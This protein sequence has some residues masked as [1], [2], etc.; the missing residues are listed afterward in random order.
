MKPTLAQSAARG[1]IWSIGGQGAIVV[2]QTI[3][4]AVLARII[5]PKDFGLVAMV[6]AIVNVGEVLRDF[7]LTSAAIQAPT[8]SRDERSNLFWVNLLSGSALAL[9]FWISAGA[10]ADFYSNPQ[11]AS[12]TR[13][14]AL[15]FLINGVATQPRANLIRDLR[16]KHLAIADV[17]GVIT[18][19]AAAISIAL[20]DHGYWAIVGMQLSRLGVMTLLVIA[21][22][23]FIPSF[24]V[25]QVSI[26]RFVRF[27]VGLFGT[28]SMI[29]IGQ[30]APTILIGRFLGPIP[31]GFFSR[32]QNLATIP[33]ASLA[34]ALQRI[35][36]PVLSR[37]QGDRERYDSFLLRGQTALLLISALGY[38]LLFVYA[39]IVIRI[40]LGSSWEAAT[41][42]FR[43]LCLAGAQDAMHYL[44][45]WI[46]VSRGNTSQYFR[47]SFVARMTLV[48]AIAIAAPLGIAAVSW[49]IAIWSVLMWPIGL[50]VA[51]SVYPLPFR[52]MVATAAR[53]YML[54]AFVMLAGSG[55]RFLA[56]DLSMPIALMLSVAALSIVCLLLTV[57]S[58]ALRKDIISLWEMVTLI[59]QHA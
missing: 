20:M 38:A 43:I 7:G 12:V 19:M 1:L 26:R 28:Q 9:L 58:R 18:G 40:F 55:T 30:N 6:M 32:A 48:L 3:T 45:D 4:I 14:L 8:L 34:P 15:T 52:T 36:L 44:L 46:Y 22:S 5:S 35:A 37:L 41:I 2:T 10:I 54:G 33:L 17:A 47:F 56:Q 16:S 57:I 39:D 23:R 29:L 13:V 42:P 49:S 53:L 51:H 50:F 59:R 21:F 11:L 31:L 25:R 24:P 27:G